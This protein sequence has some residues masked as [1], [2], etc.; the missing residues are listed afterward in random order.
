M[1]AKA[2]DGAIT[3]KENTMHLGYATALI[4]GASFFSYLD[5]AGLSI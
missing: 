2:K 4:C 1:S 5:R 3:E